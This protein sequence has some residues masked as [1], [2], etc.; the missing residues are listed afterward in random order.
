MNPALSYF[1]E[2]LRSRKGLGK[3]NDMEKNL[4][5]KRALTLVE[6]LVAA[7]LSVLVIG[8]ILMLNQFV[9]YN[10]QRARIKSH[11]IGQLETSLDLM[12]K[13][14]DQTDAYQIVGHYPTGITTYYDAVSFPLPVDIS[15]ADGYVDLTA[16][17]PYKIA[18]GQTVIYH[19]YYNTGTGK[20]E[21]RRTLFTSRNNTLTNT[22]RNNQL[23][24]VVTN[25]VP[26]IIS[27]SGTS[28]APEVWDS[29]RTLC[30]NDTISLTVTPNVGQFDGYSSLNPIRSQNIDFGGIQL[31]PTPPTGYPH[32][33]ITFTSVD[34]NSLS[35]GYG[36]GIDCFSITPGGFAR[37]AEEAT[38][39]GSNGRT[40]ANQDMYGYPAAQWSA[41]RQ[42]EYQATAPNDYISFY[43]DYDQLVETTFASFLSKNYLK[44]EY[45]KRTGDIKEEW[46]LPFT[47][48]KN[49]IVRLDGC[50]YPAWSAATQTGALGMTTP[51][52]PFIG[53]SDI[54]IRNIVSGGTMTSSGGR[55]IKVTLDNTQNANYLV[56]QEATLMEQGTSGADGKASPALNK[57]IT[58]NNGY[59]GPN[60]I[61]PEHGSLDS[62]WIDINNFQ[63][64]KNYLLTLHVTSGAG[65]MWSCWTKNDGSEQMYF[66]ESSTGTTTD[67]TAVPQWSALNPLPTKSDRIYIA[68]SIATSY[69][70]G[71][72]NSGANAIF[73]S[74]VYD[75]GVD[76]PSYTT[77][78]WNIAKNNYGSYPTGLGADLIIRVRSCSSATTLFGWGDWATYAPTVTIDTQS[79]TTGSSSINA[80]SGS[81]RR[82]FQYQL[83]FFCSPTTATKAD[84]LKSCVLKDLTIS[85]PGQSKMVDISGYFTEKPSYGIFGVTVDGKPLLKGISVS[86]TASEKMLPNPVT[87][88]LTLVTEPRNTSK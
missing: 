59:Q 67:V 41:N 83:E 45:G 61:V 82:Y 20:Y 36:I 31:D 14:L 7:S 24:D 81:N 23:A 75:T 32:H 17:A 51:G 46:S 62:D 37:E 88:S 3:G 12:K 56:I 9:Q 77:I 29:T 19:I 13:E 2:S 34:K 79:A 44:T 68:K 30:V 64:N 33:Y 58:F 16:I 38:V 1:E 80:L 66:L 25:G 49:Y 54:Y 53:T 85:W 11:V 22:Q 35:S 21:L 73:T 52:L 15:P 47:A 26:T 76:S 72:V 10:W 70:S 48:D 87:E 50:D 71:A 63:K 28:G 86:A 18:W 65:N 69:F 40:I 42:L 74:P 84:Y 78:S 27:Y 4:Y 8:A 55:A 5:R 39:A 6:I 43:F 57:Y 60:I